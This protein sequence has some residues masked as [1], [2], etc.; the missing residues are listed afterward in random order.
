MKR[1]VRGKLCGMDDW[2][3]QVAGEIKKQQ[4]AEQQAREA[5]ANRQASLS[6]RVRS[7]GH[8]VVMKIAEQVEEGLK[9]FEAE[10][11]PLGAHFQR[12][13]NGFRIDKS[14]YPSVQVKL[15]L[16]LLAGNV[17]CEWVAAM[18]S[19]VPLRM[20]EATYS[21]SL[22]GKDLRLSAPDQRS[23]DTFAD[24]VLRKFIREAFPRAHSAHL[25]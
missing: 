6:E 25:L 11:G 15:E 22:S 10:Y 16:N 18:S 21:F 20:E 5:A 3:K 2:I 7:D 1:M 23:G 9:R 4:E 13:P 19:G 17:S 12:I 24:Y 8:A 14:D